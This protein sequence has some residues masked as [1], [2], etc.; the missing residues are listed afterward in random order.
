MYY[1]LVAL[2]VVTGVAAFVYGGADD[3]PGLQLIGAVLV[4]GSAALAV[5]RARRRTP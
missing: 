1:V 5:R 4:L 3:S 2:A